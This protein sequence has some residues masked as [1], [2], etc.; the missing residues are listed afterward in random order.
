MNEDRD[1]HFFKEIIGS[2]ASP[3]NGSNTGA[4]NDLAYI[5]QAY[6]LPKWISPRLEYRARVSGEIWVYRFVGTEKRTDKNGR[7][8]EIEIWRHI[9]TPFSM[10]AWLRLL[11]ADQA[12]GV[13]MLIADRDG[14]PHAVDFQRGELARQRASEI[15]ARLMDAGMRFAPGGESTVV[16]VLKEAGPES[17]LDTVSV[18]GWHAGTF[19]TAKG[20]DL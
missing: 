20:D 8:I 12:F 10:P 9:C 16:D 5:N 18:T 7:E 17:Y 15:K 3:S 6:P 19:M 14:E 2:M 11:D 4:K 13:R 1:P